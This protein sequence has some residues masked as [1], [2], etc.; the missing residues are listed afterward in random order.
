[1]PHGEEHYA[2]TVPSMTYYGYT[3]LS[4][5]CTSTRNWTV[6][7]PGTLASGGTL[8]RGRAA[9]VHTPV[10]PDGWREPTPYWGYDYRTSAMSQPASW[11]Y[12]GRSVDQFGNNCPARI[13]KPLPG[14]TVA[15]LR[16]YRPYFSSLQSQA[17]TA[18]LA[19]LGSATAE[20]GVE[21]REAQK[22]ANFVGDQLDALWDVARSFR[23][24]RVPQSWRKA[25][26]KWRGDIPRS[27]DQAFCQ[28][29]LEYRYAWSPMILGIYDSLELLELPS[30]PM[31]VTVRKRQEAQTSTNTT[32]LNQ[33]HGNYYLYYLDIARSISE[34]QSVY[35]VLTFTPKE[36]AWITL[37]QAGVLNPAAVW[38][39]T[40]PFS[41]VVD[42]FVGVGDFLNAQ[43][44]LRLFEL[45]GGTATHRHEWLTKE[46][47]TWKAPSGYTWCVAPSVPSLSAGGSSF[48]RTVLHEADLTPGLHWGKGLNCVRALDAI[49][50]I[51]S[52]F[53][54]KSVGGLRV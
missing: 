22:T 5:G 50:L 24:G 29:W 1:M 20:L 7:G 53:K 2:V 10:A 4:T 43:Q 54:G 9:S 31:L 35:V 23:K 26:R 30:K 6:K 45:K 49:S 25:W 21:L 13:I 18:A 15:Q 34:T 42:W 37:N 32:L 38:W 11:P 36:R 46:T 28:R 19:E 33:A 3:R 41:F 51:Y 40:I 8:Y 27:F 47:Y 44:A 17:I 52:V 48:S 39:E 14:M 16:S 12:C